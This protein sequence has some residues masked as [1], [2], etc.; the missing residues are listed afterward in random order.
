[1]ETK[2]QTAMPSNLPSNSAGNSKNPPDPGNRMEKQFALMKCHSRNFAGIITYSVLPYPYLRLTYCMMFLL[3]LYFPISSTHACTHMQMYYHT[4]IY[5]SFSIKI[6]LYPFIGM[7]L[8]QFVSCASKP[9]SSLWV[10]FTEN[11][12]IIKLMLSFFFSDRQRENIS[13]APKKR[14]HQSTHDKN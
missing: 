12:A 4:C 5:H 11:G 7:K 9:N 14:M 10:D 3:F 13:I 1:M 2:S 6:T 8:S